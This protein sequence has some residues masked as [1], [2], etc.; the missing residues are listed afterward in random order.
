VRY[1]E[2]PK[3]GVAVPGQRVEIADRAQVTGRFRRGKAQLKAGAAMS[4]IDRKRIT[5]VEALEALGFTFD[6][7]RWQPSAAGLGTPAHDRDAMLGL[8]HLRAEEDGHRRLVEA[9][10]AYERALADGKV[11]GGNG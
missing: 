11:L 1:S 4:F 7:T 9:G 6:G 8:M 2:Q 3:D 10:E 5:A